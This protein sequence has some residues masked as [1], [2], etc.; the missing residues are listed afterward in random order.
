MDLTVDDAELSQGVVLRR[1]ATFFGWF[2]GFLASMATI[3][4]IPT[5]SIFIVAYMRLENR[6]PWRLVLPQAIGITI[7]MYVV[8]HRFL[9]IPWP[10][11]LLGK[12]IPALKVIPSL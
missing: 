2:V 10:A 9:A 4:L 1:A 12:L 8:F 6:E 7:F 11:T 3:G 5:A